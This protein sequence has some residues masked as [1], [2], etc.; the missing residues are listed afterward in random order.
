[1]CA[2]VKKY[3]SSLRIKSELD[4]ENRNRTATRS[5]TFSEF[6][7]R[8]WE[9][10]FATANPS[11]GGSEGRKSG[12]GTVSLIAKLHHYRKSQ[13]LDSFGSVGAGARLASNSANGLDAI[14]DSRIARRVSGPI[15]GTRASG[16][17]RAK[18]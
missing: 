4:V 8:C 13:L 7:E 18:S 10:R 15:R 17:Q 3:R 16:S 5:R 14:R 2:K 12:S 6:A 1:M 9:W 11:L